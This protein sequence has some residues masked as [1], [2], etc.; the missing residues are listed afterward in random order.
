MTATF[1][2]VAELR[3][4][5]GIGSLYDDPTLEAVCQTSEDL[6]DKMLWHNF[7]PVI[8]V[9]LTNNVATV[10]LAANTTFNVGQTITLSHTGTTYDG[11][12][13]ITGTVPYT[14][15]SPVIWYPY[16]YGYAYNGY[17]YQNLGL[18]YIQFNKTHADDVFHLIRPYGKCL[19]E[20]FNTPY[21]ETPAVR[22]AALMLAVDIWQ[23]RQAPGNGAS[24]VDF[25]TPT[26]YKM[27]RSLLSRI[28]GLLAPY[29]SPSSMVG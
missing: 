27:G 24:S 4:T 9:S 2:T 20:E 13:T 16:Q 28:S 15:G 12:H 5:L 10:T 8:A 29:M 7:V 6:I 23:A 19:G 21:A 1:V 25:G 22:E 11:A 14:S 18:S 3:A 17:P 26:P